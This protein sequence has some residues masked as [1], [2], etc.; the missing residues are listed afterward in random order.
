MCGFF[1]FFNTHSNISKQDLRKFK[2]ISRTELRRRGPDNFESALICFDKLLMCHA[3]LSIQDLSSSANQP[4]VSKSGRSRI[5]FNGEIYNHNYLRKEFL[6]KNL[7]GE[8]LRY[9]NI[10]RI[11]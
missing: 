8:Q 1:F 9:R 3:R 5:I 10:S 11:D 2:S 7:N 6:K 4:M